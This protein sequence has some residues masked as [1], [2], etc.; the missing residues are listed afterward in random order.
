MRAVLSL[1]AYQG[2][3]CQEIA[4]IE[5]D[6]VLEAKGLLRVVKGKGGHERILP[7][8]PEALAAAPDGGLGA[9]SLRRPFP[10]HLDSYGSETSCP[11]IVT[12]PASRSTLAHRIPVRSRARAPLH[13]GV[14]A[15]SSVGW[16]PS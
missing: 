5:R 11:A 13:L 16:P 3:R 2:L 7:L 1:A 12:V 14:V 9:W 4:G 6:D 15:P 10:Q 8:H